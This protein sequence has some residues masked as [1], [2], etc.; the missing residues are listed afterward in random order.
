MGQEQSAATKITMTIDHN[1]S[2]SLSAKAKMCVPFG[3]VSLT[4]EAVRL[5]NEALKAKWLTRG[6]YVQQFEEAF[7]KLFGVQY[8]VSVSSGT[9]ADALACAVLYDYGAKR[10]DEVIVPALTFIATG[11]AV[12]QAGFTPVFV[13]VNRETLNIDPLKIEAAITPK[14]RAIMPVHLM[15]KPADMDAIMTIAKKH[16][17]YVIEDT[18]EAHG[19]E[20]HGRLAG[21][22]G[23]MATFSLYA[24]HIVTSIEGG[25]VITN[26]PA[27]REILIS[28]RN[29]GIEGKFAAKRI[30]FSA[31]MNELEAAVGLGNIKIFDQILGRRRRNLLYLIDNFK[32]FDEYFISIKEGPGEKIGPHA[33]SI[34]V[35][36]GMPFTKDEFVAHLDAAGIDS[37]NLFYSI[38]TQCPSYAFLGKKLGDFPE[39]EFCSD[40][41]THIGIHQDIE[42]TD[43]DYVVEMVQK[44]L[45]CKK[46]L[47]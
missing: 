37:R 30:G 32:Q 19:A 38:P 39:A 8:A 31:K 25:M 44:F 2:A 35:R 10:G 46:L 22:I 43:L 40:H 24:A 13:D 20:Y 45:I 36:P 6:K 18:A 1:D 14:T 9:D 23:H 16:N 42:L 33:F 47:N 7:A 17:L 29:H 21:S 26:D 3:T 12:L 27:M 41:G 15:G 4:D 5:I 34:I 28:L 11:N